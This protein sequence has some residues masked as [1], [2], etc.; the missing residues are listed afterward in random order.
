MS[1]IQKY[2]EIKNSKDVPHRVFSLPQ[3]IRSKFRKI[4]PLEKLTSWPIPYK[5]GGCIRGDAPYPLG[6][7]FGLSFTPGMKGSPFFKP[8][9]SIISVN[10]VWALALCTA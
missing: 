1:S 8:A 4:Q 6:P 2:V 5:P 7:P 3:D 10:V 9:L